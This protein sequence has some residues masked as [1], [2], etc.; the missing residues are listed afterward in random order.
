MGLDGL[1]ELFHVLQHTCQ[2]HSAV[3]RVRSDQ[4]G[5]IELEH[6]R[7]SRKSSQDIQ[8]DTGKV[9]LNYLRSNII[10]GTVRGNVVPV[11]GVC[12]R[13]TPLPSLLYR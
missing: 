6:N 7:H 11:L 5:W 1:L 12:E 4:H 2:R 3:L 10:T 8:S 13:V 9:N